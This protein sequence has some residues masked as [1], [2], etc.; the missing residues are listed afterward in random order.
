M[1]S[2]GHRLVGQRVDIGVVG[3]KVERMFQIE[4]MH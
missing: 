2:Q 3:A 4:S 1:L